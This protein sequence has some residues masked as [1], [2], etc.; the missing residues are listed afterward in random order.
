MLVNPVDKRIVV[1]GMSCAGKTTFSRQL[2]GHHYYCFDALFHWHLIETL[3]LSPSHNLLHIKQNC[4]AEPFVI[5]GWHLSDVEG[6]FLPDQ[7]TVY[8]VWAPYERIISQYRVPVIDLN[9]HRSMY[10][11]WYCGV[12]YGKWDSTRFIRNDGEFREISRAEFLSSV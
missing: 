4:T 2:E 1:F 10:N 12:D 6:R 11:K 9:E 3:G 7:A 5:D 8:V